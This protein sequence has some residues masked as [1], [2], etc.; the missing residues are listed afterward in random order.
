MKA[1]SLS[2]PLYDKN[3]VCLSATHSA[4]STKIYC[5]LS[6]IDNEQETKVFLEQ[7]WSTYVANRECYELDRGTIDAYLGAK[8]E[9]DYL[10][11]R[12]VKL[13]VAMEAVKAVML[14]AGNTFVGE[15]ILAQD[16][17]KH[18][19]LALEKFLRD[20]LKARNVD[21][22]D[23]NAVYRKLPELNRRAFKELLTDLLAH[24][25]LAVAKQELDLFVKCRDSL[26]HQVR[27]YCQTATP[28]D[29]QHIPPL[30][31][32]ADEYFFLVNFL[33]KVMLKLLGYSGTYN[34][35]RLPEQFT[36][37]QI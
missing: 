32:P 25:Q 37:S 3:G 33:D 8:A 27:F 23:R 30:P 4:K 5:P 28:E 26:V 6:L 20:E 29:R 11:L 7:T 19:R 22:A 36:R 14:K 16:D 34:D 31:T 18:L 24:I 15:Y 21:S 1:Q 12:A 13:A 35:W 17:F 10:E 9:N 2:T